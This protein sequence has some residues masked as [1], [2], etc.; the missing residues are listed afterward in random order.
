MK[1]FDESK[2]IADIKDIDFYSISNADNDTLAV[3]KLIDKHAP[4]KQNLLEAITL[5]LSLKKCVR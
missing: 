5:H 4:L 3:K 1:N 2:Y